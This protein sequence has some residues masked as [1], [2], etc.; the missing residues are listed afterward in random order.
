MDLSPDIV[1]PLPDPCFAAGGRHGFSIDDSLGQS[2]IAEHGGI[3]TEPAH[4]GSRHGH[5][6][7][8][9]R[10]GLIGR[11]LD[12]FR[13]IKLMER[14]S[15]NEM[16]RGLRFEAGQVGMAMLLVETPMT[17]ADTFK[18]L[19]IQTDDLLVVP[20]GVAHG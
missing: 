6:D 16:P 17:A 19:L 18:H 11:L 9:R 4:M 2:G 8:I 5:S 20:V 13:K 10:I 7:R 1:T 12:W 14:Q 15:F 3:I